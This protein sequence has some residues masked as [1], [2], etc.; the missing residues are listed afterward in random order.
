MK[1]IFK[2]IGRYFKGVKKE[3]GRIRWTSG[4]D[5]LKYSVTTILFML[6]LGLY[7]YGIDYLVTLLRSNM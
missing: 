2:A 1:N 7:F 4:K 6:F 5:L 3:V